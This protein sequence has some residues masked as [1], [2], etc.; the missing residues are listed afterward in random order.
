MAS[1]YKPIPC[2]SP[3][4]LMN[5]NTAHGTAV[6]PSAPEPQ[7][8][9][10]CDGSNNGTVPPTLRSRWAMPIAIIH[11]SV[12]RNLISPGKSAPWK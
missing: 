1:V 10:A 5:V 9:Y 6:S 8:T 7:K 2:Y 4:W 3:E 12:G 11:S